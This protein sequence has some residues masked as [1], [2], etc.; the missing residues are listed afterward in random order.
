MTDST[1][2]DSISPIL[3]TM[4][5][6]INLE[7]PFEL[8]WSNCHYRGL[9]EIKTFNEHMHIT[10]HAIIVHYN[11]LNRHIQYEELEWADPNLLDKLQLILDSMANYS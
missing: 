7:S 10:E 2:L 9:I 5:D 6:E 4:V 3:R 11:R 1:I 8:L